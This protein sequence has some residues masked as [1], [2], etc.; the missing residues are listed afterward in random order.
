MPDSQNPQVPN[1]VPGVGRL[2]TDR[3]DF[4]SHVN[5]TAFRHNATQIDLFPTL[6]IESV[7]CTTVQQALNELVTFIVAPTVQ[8]ATIG[9]MSSNLGTVTLGGDFAGVGSTALSPRVGAIQGNPIQNIAPTT[10]Q[11]L[12]WNSGGYWYPAV[13]SG[14][15]ASHDLSGSATSQTVIGIQGKSVPTPSGTNTILSWSG[16]ALSWTTGSFFSA[17]GDL[18]GSNVSQTVIGID[19][20]PIVLTSL[21]TNQILQYNGTNW[22]NANLPT[23]AGGDLTGTYPNPTIAKL[24]GIT[25]SASSPSTGQVLEYNGTDWVPATVSGGGGTRAYF[26]TGVDG[27]VHFDGTSTVLGIVPVSSVYTFTGPSAPGRCI[28]PATMIVDSGVTVKISGFA[29]FCNGTLTNNGTIDT[30]GPAASGTTQG[31]AIGWFFYGCGTAGGGSGSNGTNFGPSFG[32]GG[33]GGVGGTG[34]GGSGGTGGTLN[35][36]GVTLGSGQSMTTYLSGNVIYSSSPNNASG[37][38]TTTIFGGGSGGGG[39]GGNFTGGQ[40]GGGGAGGGYMLI[41][42]YN[43]TGLGHFNANGGAGGTVATAGCGGGGGGG[44]GIIYIVY[45]TTGG[46]LS[47]SA[48]GGAGGVGPNANGI[49]GGNGQILLVQG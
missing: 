44:G 34:I 37:T 31:S 35:G 39:G 1:Y 6:V 41:T 22:V 26:G 38:V 13:S 14:F 15:T 36:G 32:F 42:A 11:V 4:E 17:G 45:G 24:Q 33:V 12:T 7:T 49:A 25:V 20:I 46:V 3:Y 28:Q 23:T 9:S 19:G 48:N 27:Y 40:G 5:G 43:L 8:Q 29:I 47:Y 10:G 30:S 2:V 21:S 16:T 18:G